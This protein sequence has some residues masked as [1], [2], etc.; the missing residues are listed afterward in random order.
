MDLLIRT[1]ALLLKVF[2]FLFTPLNALISWIKYRDIQIPAITNELLRLPAVDLAA[3][4]RNREVTA[5]AVVQ[6]YVQRVKLVNPLINAVVEDRFMAALVDADRADKLAQQLT[7][8]QLIQEYPLL[9]VPFT[10][11]ESIAT[12]GNLSREEREGGGSAGY[13]G[14]PS[15]VHIG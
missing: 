15:W 1:L 6:A 4:I 10:V 11:K 7:Q 14:N 2:G 13:S 5:V 12:K 8:V 3:K 9:G